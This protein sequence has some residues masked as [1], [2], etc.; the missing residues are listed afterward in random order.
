MKIKKSPN[1]DGLPECKE[2]NGVRSKQLLLWVQDWET[3]VFGYYVTHGYW[4]LLP[5]SGEY[6]T[7][8]IFYYCDM[9]EIK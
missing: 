5:S 8:E 1:V 4:R 7:N 9:D 6:S 2:N 3:P